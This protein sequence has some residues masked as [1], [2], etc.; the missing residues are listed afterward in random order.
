MRMVTANLLWRLWHGSKALEMDYLH[1]KCTTTL[2]KTM[3]EETVFWDLN[4]AIKY[5]ALGTDEVRTKVLKTMETLDQRLF[6]H[7]NFVWLEHASVKELL[8]R[9]KPNS[10]EALI[11]YNNLLRWS[12]YQLDRSACGEIEGGLT[13]AQIPI[14]IRLEWIG[15]CRNGDF[16]HVTVKDMDKYLSRGLK[17]MPWTE[18]SQSDFLVY[19]VNAKVVPE[20]V[21]ASNAIKIMEIVV[22]NPDRLHSSAFAQSNV[23]EKS[24]ISA[25]F[26]TSKTAGVGKLGHLESTTRG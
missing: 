24:K 9:R 15:Q 19:V 18:M 16:N 3:C 4:Y 1:A 8:K 13:G 6:E 12:L 22:N 7:P 26:N 17:E 21:V 10:C 14:N 23:K 11:V 20:E 2:H 25:L 5:K